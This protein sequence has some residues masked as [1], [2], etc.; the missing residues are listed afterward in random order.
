MMNLSLNKK[1]TVFQK[2]RRRDL[3]H[4]E[5]VVVS[6]LMSSDRVSLTHKQLTNSRN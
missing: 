1:K 6:L 3:G 2:F 4:F 5:E